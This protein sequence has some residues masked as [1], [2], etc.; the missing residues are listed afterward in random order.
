M[1]IVC[2]ST[3]RTLCRLELGDVIV[4]CSSL[5]PDKVTFT[6]YVL[7]LKIYLITN[8]INASKF[9]NEVK[10]II[11]IVTIPGSLLKK[12]LLKVWDRKKKKEN[13]QELNEFENDSF[14]NLILLQAA[15][16]HYA[17]YFFH[18]DFKM[19]RYDES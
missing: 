14:Y 5:P 15:P 13:G 3:W 16:F 1:S 7:F 11:S 19:E 12:I 2:K 4:Q 6:Y 8:E 17:I 9:V 10:T 18:L